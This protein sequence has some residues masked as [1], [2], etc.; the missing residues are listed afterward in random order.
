MKKKTDTTQIGEQEPLG[1]IISR[2]PSQEQVPTFFAYVWGPDPEADETGA[3]KA[4]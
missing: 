3:T 1:I 4:A 2:G